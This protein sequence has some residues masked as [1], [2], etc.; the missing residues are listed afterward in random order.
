MR[1]MKINMIRIWLYTNNKKIFGQNKGY[2]KIDQHLA[3]H[4]VYYVEFLSNPPPFLCRQIIT[5][6]QN[7]II[8][9]NHEK[10]LV[11]QPIVKP[12][13]PYSSSSV[14]S[15]LAELI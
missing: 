2:C 10:G 3:R 4:L 7:L 5:P 12:L 14:E 6:F 1:L 13:Y 11:F 9:T 15:L 8:S